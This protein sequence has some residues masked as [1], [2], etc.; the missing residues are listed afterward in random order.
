V[1]LFGLLIACSSNSIPAIVIAR[2]NLQP[3][4]DGMQSVVETFDLA[5]RPGSIVVTGPELCADAIH[6][7]GN[8]FDFPASPP[9]GCGSVLSQLPARVI[10]H[11]L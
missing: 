2:A 1:Q 10:D 4:F 7:M 3:F 5:A 9:V 11:A 8:V 6:V